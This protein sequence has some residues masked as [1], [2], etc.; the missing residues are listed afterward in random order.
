MLNALSKSEAVIE[1]SKGLTRRAPFK[2][3]EHAE[4]SDTMVTPADAGFLCEYMNSSGC[5]LS[6]S[7]TGVDTKMSEARHK[8]NRFAIGS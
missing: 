1:M 8:A 3:L 6:P 2:T 4:N 7:R 5:K